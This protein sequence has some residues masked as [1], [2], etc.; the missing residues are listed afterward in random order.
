MSPPRL[1]DDGAERKPPAALPPQV[2]A[3]LRG[4]LGAPLYAL[5]AEAE[6][7]IRRGEA[8]KDDALRTAGH[9]ILQLSRELVAGL[10]AMR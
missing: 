5:L 8:E 7:L 9:R 3:R 10:R 6:L 2:A 1:G 4:E